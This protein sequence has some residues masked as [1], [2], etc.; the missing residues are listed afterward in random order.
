MSSTLEPTVNMRGIYNHS[1]ILGRP[2]ESTNVTCVATYGTL[3]Y[4]RTIT[5]QG[6]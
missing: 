1:L 5:L 4:N 2:S 3:V 6:L